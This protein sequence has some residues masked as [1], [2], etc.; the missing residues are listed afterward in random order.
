[1]LNVIQRYADED[2]A[3]AAKREIEVNFERILAPDITRRA[4]LTCRLRCT[5]PLCTEERQVNLLARISAWTLSS[6]LPP[7]PCVVD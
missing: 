1:M 4:L 2:Q 5:V 6:C 3:A 7:N